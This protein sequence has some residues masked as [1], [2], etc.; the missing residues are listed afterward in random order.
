MQHWAEWWSPC[1]VGRVNF[2]KYAWN[3]SQSLQAEG[4]AG[5]THSPP[6]PTACTCM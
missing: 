1:A 6:F 5:C 3:H 2:L 4:D